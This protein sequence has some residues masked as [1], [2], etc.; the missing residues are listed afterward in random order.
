[1]VDDGADDGLLGADE[2]RALAGVREALEGVER[3]QGRILRERGRLRDQLE[4]LLGGLRANGVVLSFDAA[5]TLVGADGAVDRLLGISADEL[6]SNFDEIATGAMREAVEEANRKAL[7]SSSSVAESDGSLRCGGA[8][9]AFHWIHVPRSDGGGDVVGV[10]VIGV[11]LVDTAPG[12]DS[13]DGAD[14]FETLV[15]ETAQSIID[16]AGDASI[17]RALKAFGESF[18]VDRVVINGYEGG[19]HKFLVRSSWLRS[20]TEPL[21]AENR[22]ISRSE[23]PWAYSQLGA[24]EMVVISE[25]AELPPDAAAELRLYASEGAKT[26]LLV[27]IARRGALFAFVSMQTVDAEREW[28]DAQLVR[29]RRFGMLLSGALAQASAVAVLEAAR[30]EASDAVGRAEEA[31]RKAERAEEKVEDAEERAQEAQQRVD[32]ISDEAEKARSR[33]AELEVELETAGQETRA[34]RELSAAAD[35]RIRNAE[36]AVDDVRSELDGVKQEAAEAQCELDDLKEE[37]ERAQRRSEDTAADALVVRKRLGEARADAEAGRREAAEARVEL[38]ELR[39]GVR[40]DASTAAS[41][42]ES[43]VVA[44]EA[45]LEAEFEAAFEADPKDE[46]E[47]GPEGE[48]EAEREAEK[49]SVVFG[50]HD[51]DATIELETRDLDPAAAAEPDTSDLDAIAAAE[52]SAG[53]FD[54]D[55]TLEIESPGDGLPRDLGLDEILEKT[56]AVEESTSAAEIAG[57]DPEPDVSSGVDATVEVPGPPSHETELLDGAGDAADAD[58]NVADLDDA[59]PELAEPDGPTIDVEEPAAAE[60]AREVEEARQMARQVAGKGGDESFRDADDADTID[61]EDEALDVLDGEAPASPGSPG[62]DPTI[63]LQ[64]VG[65]NVELYRNLLSKFRQDYLG[66]A[67]KIESAIAKGNIEVAH[68]LLHAVKGVGGML[69]A[70]RVRSTAEDLETSLIGSDETTSQAA[71]D[72]FTGAL[73]EVLDSITALDGGAELLPAEPA[74]ASIAE[75]HVSDPMVLRSYLS[76]LRHHL[77]SEKSKQC[78]LVMREIT[79]RTWPGEFNDQVAEL[80]G[81]IGA[82]EF[83][84]AR[85][86]FDALVSKLDDN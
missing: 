28:S 40:E 6:V 77:L 65:G 11:L 10:E 57:P 32:E 52:R 54:P 80:A 61:E 66:A 1:M 74:A 30:N 3:E 39:E 64:D 4:G 25:A 78:Q 59:D 45:E 72:A 70:E 5:G 76:G 18:G 41:E 27:P 22:G 42:S 49:E 82:H 21:D 20:G 62:I 38:Q 13:V 29:A 33:V 86:V 48:L 37:A 44:P 7:G 50:D 75:K 73:N 23:I 79:A 16:D 51:L 84:T 15:I 47:D 85:H 31:E 53:Q 2:L 43:P 26:S 63:G 60:V 46:P 14:P 71:L 81:L 8:E 36:V 83:D 68:L 9:H 58:P 69:G 55:A 17:G 24:G 12:D 56:D 67:A 35:E 19:D 34:A